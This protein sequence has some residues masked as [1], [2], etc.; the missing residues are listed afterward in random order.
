VVGS[1]AAAG[2]PCAEQSPMI[3]HSGEVESERGRTV[4]ASVGFIGAGAGAS[5]GT[6]LAWR[7]AARVG[8]SA[9]ACSG[10]AGARRTRGCVILPKFLRLLSTQTCESCHMACVRFL[11]YTY[12]YLVHVSSKGIYALAWEIWRHQVSVVGTVQP[13]TKQVSTRVKWS[14]LWF[15]RFQCVP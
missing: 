14:W 10:V 9:R 15:K 11:P 6:G 1:R 4:E 2:T 13:E 8:P 3:L 5:V 12:S 7:G